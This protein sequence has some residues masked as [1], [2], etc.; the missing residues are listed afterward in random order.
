MTDDCLNCNSG[1]VYKCAD[2]LE[3]CA[4]TQ[5]SF[6]ILCVCPLD[7][8]VPDRS[9]AG[10][11]G[12]SISN[13]QQQSAGDCDTTI[14][15]RHSRPQPTDALCLCCCPYGGLHN[16]KSSYIKK[17]HHFVFYQSYNK[18][19]SLHPVPFRRSQSQ[20]EKVHLVFTF[21]LIFFIAVLS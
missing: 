16:V 15:L 19:L 17:S 3:A 12:H 11:S 1:N 8:G 10:G 14:T 5:L 7:A 2:L 4:L 18:T 13:G 21:F 20:V 6:C 9:S